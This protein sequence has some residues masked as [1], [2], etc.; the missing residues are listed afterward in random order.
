[1]REKTLIIAEAGVNHNGDLSI[2][3]R[4]IDV[5]SDAG[6]DIVKFQTFVAKKLVSPAAT[7]AAYQQQNFSENSNSQLNMLKR[8]ELDTPQHKI[9]INYCQEKKITFLSTAFDLES[10]DLLN[11]LGI[12]LFKI[13]SGEITN[14]P[15][16]QK[17]GSLLKPVIL[18]TGMSKLGEIEDA[19]NVLLACGLQREKITVLQCNTEY[20][21]PMQD[22]NLRAMNTIARAFNIKVGYSDHT[23]GIEVPIA[24]VA[25]GASVIEKHFTL[26]RNLPG[27]D[28]QASLEPDEL[29]QMVKAIRNIEH[30]LGSSLKLP[31]ASEKPNIHVARK[32]IHL[33][34]DKLKDEVITATDL[35][36][37]RPGN[38]ISPM[39]YESLIGRKVNHH[40]RAGHQLTWKDLN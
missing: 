10:I 33:A 36:M 18:S 29:R 14:L 20:P 7:M 35:I 30:A 38:G 6:A 16:L 22:V 12:S 31:S 32:S 23:L 3:K 1:M 5:A 19:L 17:I 15:M 37:L 4:L 21:T 11:M 9:L 40:L 8:L 34:V 2:A 27:P 13:P 24:A 26:D 39:Q 28:H 25:L